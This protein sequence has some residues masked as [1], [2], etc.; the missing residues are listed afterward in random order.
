MYIVVEKDSN[1]SYI[2]KE[3]THLSEKI[4][5]STKTILR[6]EDK[7]MWETS[8]YYIYNPV[9]IQNRSLRGKK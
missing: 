5:R 7:L 9:F 3:K 2:F 8:K 4:G 6:N 1:K